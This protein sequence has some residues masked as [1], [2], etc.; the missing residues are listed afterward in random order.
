[1]PDPD[2]RRVWLVENTADGADIAVEIVSI[3]VQLRKRVRVGITH[4]E[5]QQL[6]DLLL[7]MS[8][9]AVAAVEETKTRSTKITGTPETGDK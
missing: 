9:N 1:V 3:D 5:R 8:A 2:D 4:E 6:A 7:R